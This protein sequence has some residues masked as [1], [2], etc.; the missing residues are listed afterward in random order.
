MVLQIDAKVPIVD[1]QVD[2]ADREYFILHLSPID[3]PLPGLEFGTSISVG[4]TAD[5]DGRSE[6]IICVDEVINYLI[7]TRNGQVF[8]CTQ[9]TYC[10]K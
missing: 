9:Q 7:T 1:D 8:Q 10:L 3:D 6:A 2:E 4:E 5:D